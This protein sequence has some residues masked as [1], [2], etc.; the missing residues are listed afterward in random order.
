MK[1]DYYFLIRYAIE[2][3]QWKCCCDNQAEYLI[4][5]ICVS[6]YLVSCCYV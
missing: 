1:T 3:T 2:L 4:N 5:V 6:L